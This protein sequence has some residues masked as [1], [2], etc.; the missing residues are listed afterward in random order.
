MKIW[1]AAWI[2]LGWSASGIAASLQSAPP[3]T[4]PAP[5]EA[6]PAERPLEIRVTSRGERV[7]VKAGETLVGESPTAPGQE[8]RL[9]V[10]KGPVRVELLDPA[11]A[12]AASVELAPAEPPVARVGEVQ[13]V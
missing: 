12:V 1:T 10:P 3:S 7:R 2:A 8:V 5:Q 4:S 11:G 9:R 13:L 6:A